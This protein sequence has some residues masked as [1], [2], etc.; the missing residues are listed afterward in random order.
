MI[1]FWCLM[2]K[3]EKLRPKQMDH[4]PLVNFENN[5][6]RTFDLSKILLLQNLVSCG[7]AY[8]KIW[9]DYGKKGELLTL[10]QFYSWNN[11]LCAQTSVFD[12]EIGKRI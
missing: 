2:P 7:G 10:D 5:R 3:G 12:L 11:S 1:S 6:V 9:F 8:C 4:L